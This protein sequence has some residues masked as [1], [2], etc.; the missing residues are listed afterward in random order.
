M[1]IFREAPSGNQT[2]RCP[3]FNSRPPV[4]PQVLRPE[5]LSTLSRQHIEASLRTAFWGLLALG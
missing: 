3:S 5:A 4:R 1:I 2:P